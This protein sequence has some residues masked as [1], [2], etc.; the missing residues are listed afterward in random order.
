MT[1]LIL[2]HANTSNEKHTQLITVNNSTSLLLTLLQTLK[3]SDLDFNEKLSNFKQKW[4][5]AKI[6]AAQFCCIKT[7][8]HSLS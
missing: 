6:L 2:A 1:D 3:K 4:K 8:C 7:Q 5:N